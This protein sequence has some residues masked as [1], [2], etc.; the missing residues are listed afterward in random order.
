MADDNALTPMEVFG[1]GL[2]LDRMLEEFGDDAVLQSARDKLD[3]VLMNAQRIDPTLIERIKAHQELMIR[4]RRAA[5]AER[6]GDR[7]K[8]EERE[9]HRRARLAR[10][11]LP[12]PSQRPRW[13]N[14]DDD[15]LGY[16]L[17]D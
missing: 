1:A 8:A 6:E 10:L 5:H 16:R 12:V 9:K 7:A 2:A 17:G 11:G 3:R 13:V 15:D 14:E 4:G